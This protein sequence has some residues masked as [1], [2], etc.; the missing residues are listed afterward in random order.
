VNGV[1]DYKGPGDVTMSPFSS[2]GPVDDGRIKPD[3]VAMGM[4]VFST[5]INE[6]QSDS[7]TTLSG[8]SMAAPN[9][10]GSLFLL[11]ELYHSRNAGRYMR[12][13][14]LKALAIHTAKEAG[15]AP[16]PDYMYGWGLLDVKSA[17]EMIIN[18][19]GSSNIIRELVLQNNQVYEFDF[20]SDGI[21]PAKV[22]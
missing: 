17:A 7:Y 11:Q 18:E 3:L 22:T 1:A 8:T 15:L 13:A 4:N 14:T 19:N 6:E 9:A 20:I 16:G 12:A 5:A 2:W 10:T 21:S